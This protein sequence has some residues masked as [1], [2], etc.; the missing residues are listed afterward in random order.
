MQFVS[1][2]WGLGRAQ[3]QLLGESVAFDVDFSLDTGAES[4]LSYE[5][6]CRVS[7][8]VLLQAAPPPLST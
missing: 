5:A 2:S 6:M 4:K 7:A 1:C 8:P 3:L